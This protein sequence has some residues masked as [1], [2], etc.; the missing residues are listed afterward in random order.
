MSW[1]CRKDKVPV[2][3]RRGGP[4]EN[5]LSTTVSSLAHQ[6]AE[7]CASQCIPPPLPH[8]CARDLRVPAIPESWPQHLQEA[9]HHR[10]LPFPGLPALWR[11]YTLQSNTQHCQPLRKG[12]QPRKLEQALH[13]CAKSASIA[14]QSCQLR[15]PWGR[16]PWVL[17]G[18][19][20]CSHPQGVLHFVE[21]LTSTTSPLEELHNPETPEQALHSHVKSTSISGGT[22]QFRLTSGSPLFL[23]RDP[24]STAHP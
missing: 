21:W 1:I 5:T 20:F 16:A 6:L 12:P 17:S 22:S 15:L 23:Q 13:S 2:L 11:G 8:T 10:G 9:D 7:S 3:E 19:G 24:V 18:P 4:P 14:E